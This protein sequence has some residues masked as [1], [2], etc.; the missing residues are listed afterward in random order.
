MGRPKKNTATTQK[1]LS[2]SSKGNEALSK[3]I[4][5]LQN[6]PI[7]TQVLAGSTILGRFLPFA[8]ERDDPNFE[9]LAVQCA[10][11]CYAWGDA[12]LAFA[13]LESV[14]V[15]SSTRN[16]RK[17]K[18]TAINKESQPTKKTKSSQKANKL[19][20]SMGLNL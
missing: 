9:A 17:Q 8:I 3:T 5:Y 1:H 10:K 19:V 2:L 20:Q 11:N 6:H 18:N 15:S 13:G 16:V 14:R 7:N 4:A 12:I